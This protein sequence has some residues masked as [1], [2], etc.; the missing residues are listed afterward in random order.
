MKYR[1]SL[2]PNQATLA[3]FL[4]GQLN[5]SPLLAQCLLNRGLSEAEPITR[6]LSPRLQH[7][8]DPFL[9]PDMRGAVA[10]LLTARARR[11]P[12]TIFGDYDVDGVTATALLTEFLTA[13]GWEVRHY[14]PHRM[15][16]G[17]GLSQ[18]GVENC[19]ELHPTSVL[20][21]VDCG[22]TAVEAVRWL[23]TR[24]V[25]VIVLDHHQVSSPSPAAVALVNPQRATPSE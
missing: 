22:S 23:R 16:E 2:A 3:G 1:W 5:L 24:G 18:T 10:R 12:V 21:A 17:Y 14:L 20:L 6:F 13:L 25:D 15:D 11:E 7:L 8:A 4:A 9:L 19:L